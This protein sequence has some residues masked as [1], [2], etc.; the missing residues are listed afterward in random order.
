MT[1]TRD[2]VISTA[3]RFVGGT[4]TCRVRFMVRYTAWRGESVRLVGADAALGAWNPDNSVPMRHANGIWSADVNVPSGRCHEYKFVLFD[5]EGRFQAWQGGSD[6]V[7]AVYRSDERLEVRDDWSGDPTLSNV[8][9]PPSAS[10]AAA[11]VAPKLQ[12]RQARLLHMLSCLAAAVN[13]ADAADETHA[14]R[15]A[16]LAAAV[17]AAQQAQQ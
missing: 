9:T 17:D 16:A 2:G 13:A 4:S 10:D 5:A 15:L 3:R 7:L 11:G 14:K 1:A 6:A 12:S 8:L